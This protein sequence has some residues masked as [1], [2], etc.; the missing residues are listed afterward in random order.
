MKP[1]IGYEVE[2]ITLRGR[3]PAGQSFEPKCAPG[4]KTL[5]AGYE[6]VGAEDFTFDRIV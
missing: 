1:N 6:D 3:M 2:K 5:G 4:R